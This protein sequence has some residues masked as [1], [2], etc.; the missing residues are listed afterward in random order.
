MDKHSK[1]VRS[2]NMSQIRSTNSKP[3]I[4]VRKYLFSKGLRYR[5]NVRTLPGKPDIVLPKYKTIVFV[6]GCFWHGHKDC[7]YFVMPKTNVEFWENKISNNI[8]RDNETYNKLS[9][10]GWNII[11]VWECDLKKNKR[12]NT[13]DYL[14]YNIIRNIKEKVSCKKELNPIAVIIVTAMGVS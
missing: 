11:V 8:S 9:N 3:E 4:I 1:N 6:N 10:L 12:E 14:Y 5:K 13:L 2:Y 7:K